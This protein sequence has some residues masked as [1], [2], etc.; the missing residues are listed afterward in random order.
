MHRAERRCSIQEAERCWA[1]GSSGVSCRTKAGAGLPWPKV[2]AA[3][4]ERRDE[5]QGACE[6]AERRKGRGCMVALNGDTEGS[7]RSCLSSSRGSLTWESAS[8]TVWCFPFFF[9]GRKKHTEVGCLTAGRAAVDDKLGMFLDRHVG[10]EAVR[11]KSRSGAVDAGQVGL[12]VCA[13]DVDVETRVERCK[14]TIYECLYICLY[15]NLCRNRVSKESGLGGGS[16]LEQLR[17]RAEDV[18][19]GDGERS[20]ATKT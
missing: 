17:N 7:S 3:R 4:P 12:V 1:S 8:G 14:M 18:V 2:D 15:I 10:C 19:T 11:Y 20:G 13:V 6:E 16:E 9:F 5:D